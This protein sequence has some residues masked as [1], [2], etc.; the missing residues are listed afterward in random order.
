[1]EKYYSVKQITRLAGVTVKTLHLY[2]KIGLL[3]PSVRT[4]ANYRQYG[5]AELLRLQQI[6]FYRELDIPLKSII[7]I[8]NDPHFDLAKALTSHRVALTARRDRL[9][10]LM[11]T[12]EE[13]YEGMPKEQAEAY[14]KEAIEK[15]GED[16]VVRSEKALLE[17]DKLDLEKLKADQKEINLKLQSLV[18]SDPESDTVQE[19]IARHYTNIRAF[20]GVSD[21]TDL[22]AETYKGLAELYVADERYTMSDGKPNPEFASFMRKGMIYFADSKLIKTN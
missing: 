22:R 13:L 4:W 17:M 12:I 2:D 9:N 10:T 8:M 3:K 5:H 14:R 19:Q 15:W 18:E 6:L 11:S 16:T 1:M 20:W 7:E 21:P